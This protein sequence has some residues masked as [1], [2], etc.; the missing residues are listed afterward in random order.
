MM[1]PLAKVDQGDMERPPP[2]AILR[3]FF[4]LFQKNIRKNARATWS[5]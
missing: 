1:M 4:I 3:P 2:A 5:Y